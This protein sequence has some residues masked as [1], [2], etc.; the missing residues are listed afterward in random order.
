M[1]RFAISR[2]VIV[3]VSD[4]IS[5]EIA[6]VVLREFHDCKIS[7]MYKIHLTVGKKG[8]ERSLDSACLPAYLL[9]SG[10]IPTMNTRMLPTRLRYMPMPYLIVSMVVST[11]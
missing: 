9:N 10:R 6:V 1:Q 7:S 8:E 11:R 3:A 4:R 5:A 2:A